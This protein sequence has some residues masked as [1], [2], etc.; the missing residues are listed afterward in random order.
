[1]V[2]LCSQF[3][4]ETSRK[5]STSYTNG[6]GLFVKDKGRPLIEAAINLIA[7]IILVK[8][9]GIAGVFW[10]T[11]LSHLCTVTWREP[12]L[13][14][15]YEFKKP[16]SKYWSYFLTACIVTV[17]LCITFN[18]LFSTINYDVC[19]F[20]MWFIKAFSIF[21]SINLIGVVLFHKNKDFV[22]YINLA[23]QKMMERK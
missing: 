8:R 10:G 15:I 16:F 3:F 7:S 18:T 1:V 20:L 6:C 14:Y 22:F 9:M 19:N 23:K 12:Y 13:L 11:V 4:L 5:I 2:A 17:L 21:V